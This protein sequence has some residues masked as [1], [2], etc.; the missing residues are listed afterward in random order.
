MQTYKKIGVVVVLYNPGAKE[1]KTIESYPKN[2]DYIVLVDNSKEDN[3]YLF[4]EILGDQIIYKCLN[5]NTGIAHALN[6][7]VEFLIPRVDFILTMDQDSLLESSVID[8]YRDFISNNPQEISYAL[9]PKYNT[10]RHPS[11]PSNGCKYM[12]LS[13]QS[14]TLFSKD[15]F[16]KIGLFNEKLFMDVTDWEFFLRMRKNNFKLIRCNKAV[17]NHHPAKTE[18]KNLFILKLKYGVASPTRYYYQARNLLWTGRE[19]KSA[20][21]YTYLL[22]KYLKIVLLFDNKKEYLKYFKKGLRD[23]KDL[24]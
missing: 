16:Q 13:M 6:E 9:T 21:M 4:K 17:L 24:G 7:G 23:A 14:G 3:S 2:L 1:V 22:I 20:L 5:K 12:L 18:S 15:I 10:D 8:T 19:Y 11:K